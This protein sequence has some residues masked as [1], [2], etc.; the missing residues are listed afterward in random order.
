VAIARPAALRR[1]AG[2]L[3]VDR[4]L[5]ELDLPLDVLPPPIDEVVFAQ[6][7]YLTS[8]DRRGT[9]GTRSERSLLGFADSAGSA[10]TVVRRIG[11]RNG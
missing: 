10:F 4:A 11:C 3:D 9:R 7:T 2:E 6:I 1:A 8:E 5:V